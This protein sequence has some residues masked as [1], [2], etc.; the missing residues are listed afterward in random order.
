[1]NYY[2]PFGAHV[3]YLP[4]SF[5][6]FW[7]WWMVLKKR[8][9][10]IIYVFLINSKFWIDPVTLIGTKWNNVKSSY[11]KAVS[12]QVQLYLHSL[13]LRI[14]FPIA[15][16]EYDLSWQFYWHFLKTFSP[17]QTIQNFNPQT[18]GTKASIITLWNQRLSPP[19]CGGLRRV[20]W[21][22]PSL[23]KINRH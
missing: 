1:M 21:F 15:H 20:L 10:L 9:K 7:L 3:D 18:M 13:V 5:P 2:L 16:I 17:L 22:S 19:K 6:I 12:C 4:R 23:F 14:L 8:S 11:H